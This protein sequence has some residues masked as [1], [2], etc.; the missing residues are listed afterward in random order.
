MSK[1][2]RKMMVDPAIITIQIDVILFSVQNSLYGEGT[3]LSSELA[4]SMPYAPTGKAWD[5][6]ILGHKL[7][8][9]AVCEIID[10]PSVKCQL[11][12]DHY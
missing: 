8:C 9:F 4:V 11:K 2:L 1:F 7:S 12:G 10:D 3:Y 5:K 6:S